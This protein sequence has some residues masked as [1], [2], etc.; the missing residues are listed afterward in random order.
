MYGDIE[1]KVD[2]ATEDLQ[3]VLEHFAVVCK[4]L[5]ERFKEFSELLISDD[6]IEIR[7]KAKF[8]PCMRIGFLRTYNNDARKLWQKNKA[9]YLCP[10]MPKA[11]R[12]KK[13]RI[14]EA[15]L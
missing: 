9:L 5:A 7:I 13:Q 2:A 14:K 8:K 6:D 11:L 10:Y 12:N 15:L 1:R 3:E 4:E